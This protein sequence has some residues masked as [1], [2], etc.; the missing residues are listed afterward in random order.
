M[1]QKAF[2]QQVAQHI[3]RAAA[4]V[5]TKTIREQ[6]SNTCGYRNRKNRI[7]MLGKTDGGEFRLWIVPCQQLLSPVVVG[8]IVYTCFLQVI[9]NRLAALLQ[10]QLQYFKFFFCHNTITVVVGGTIA[11]QRYYETT[12]AATCIST[13]AYTLGL[14]MPSNEIPTSSSSRKFTE[15]P[16]R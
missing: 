15:R 2:V 8:G 1:D 3:L 6:E 14:S 11:L 9:L 7:S 10:V 13:N 12:T 5:G 4:E 16:L